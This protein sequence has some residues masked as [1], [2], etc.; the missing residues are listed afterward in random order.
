MYTS[1]KISFQN[2][3]YGTNHLYN[4]CNLHDMIKHPSHQLPFIVSRLLTVYHQAEN[5]F[6]SIAF[7]QE[8]IYL[9]FF[10]FTYTRWTDAVEFEKAD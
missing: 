9:G 3:H 2:E 4:V 7:T 1:Q 8:N 10:H 6:L 5:I